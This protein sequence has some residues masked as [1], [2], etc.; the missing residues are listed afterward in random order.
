M[1]R[2]VCFFRIPS[3]AEMEV[4]PELFVTSLFYKVRARAHGAA[5]GARTPADRAGVMA[6]VRRPRPPE[7]HRCVAAP[8]GPNPKLFGYGRYNDG[9]DCNET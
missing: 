8:G 7:P 2:S 5:A 9:N 1:Y 6:G 3:V 4:A